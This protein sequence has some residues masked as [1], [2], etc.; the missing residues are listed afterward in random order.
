MQRI[1]DAR[2]LACGAGRAGLAP[3]SAST[4][5]ITTD[6]PAQIR[7]AALPPNATVQL[8]GQ[9]ASRRSIGRSI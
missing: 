3:L 1:G 6:T 2:L 8:D 7:L 5:N 9:P 4:I